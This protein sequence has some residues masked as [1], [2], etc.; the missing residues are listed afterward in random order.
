[1]IE[2]LRI[3]AWNANGLPQHTR[4]LELFLL[5]QK[6]DIVLLSETHFTSKSV[7][8]LPRYSTYMTLRPDG[9]AHGGTAVLIKTSLPHHESTP[10]QTMSLQATSVKIDTLPFPVTISAIYCPPGHCMQPQDFTSYFSTLGTKFIAGGDWNAKHTFWGS[11]LISPRGRSLYNATRA[12]SF[13]FISTGEPTHWPSDPARKPDLIDFFVTH[14]VATNYTHIESNDDLSSDHSPLIL[15]LSTAVITK[16]TNPKLT[17]SKTNWEQYKAYMDENTSLSLRLKDPNDI[18]EAAQYLTALIQKGAVLATPEDKCIMSSNNIPK[19]IKDLIAEKRRQRKKW[20]N[21]R[22][23]NDKRLLNQLTRKIQSL[24][25][26]RHNESFGNYLLSLSINDN[27]LWNA[28]K[29]LKRPQ[30]QVPALKKGPALYARSSAEKA[31]MFGDHLSSVFQPFPPAADTDLEEQTEIEKFLDVPCQMAMPIKPISPS[32]IQYA[33]KIIKKNKAPGYDLITGKMLQELPNMTIILITHI[34]NAMLRLSYWP[35]IWKY[36]DIIM[37]QKPNKPSEEVSS[38]RPISLLPAL[39][40]LFERIF[41]P[42][43]MEENSAKDIVPDHQFGFRS[44]HSTIQQVHRVVNVVASTLEE[45]SHC[46]AAFLD[47]ASA[48]DKVWHTGLLHKLKTLIPQPHYL[49]LKS[50]LSDRFFRVKHDGLYSSYHKI[51]AGVPQ[52]SVLGPFLYVLY[53]NDIPRTDNT[54]L[55]TF[56][57]DTAILSKHQ[58]PVI[59]SDGLQNYLN[60]LQKWLKTWRICVNE[61]KSVHMTFTT[62]TTSCPPVA[63]NNQLLPQDDKVRYLGV[64]LDRKLNWKHHITTK[65]L[66]LKLKYNKM[67]WLLGSKSKLS[68]ENKIILYK[69]VLKPVWTYGIELWGCAKPSNINIIQRFQSK[70]LRQM[71]GA[72]YYVSNKTI[73]EDLQIPFIQEEIKNRPKNYQRRIPGHQNQLIR[74]LQN[75]ITNNKRLKRTYPIDLFSVN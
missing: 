61:G 4:E 69:M 49:L 58:D 34:F 3:L 24:L 19:E 41:L 9:K 59:A 13:N 74:D 25:K 6:I 27:S 21:K 37:V 72:P 33:L 50:Y 39:S 62:R 17:S 66:Q 16:P 55:A 23:P 52:G 42:K 73:H 67:F 45:K 8:R 70:T 11:R 31:N 75:P 65:R 51:S 64:H 14:G 15:T 56:A 54:T 40:K 60:Q 20:Q 1:M 29:G 35:R 30:K 2:S 7:F 26:E 22:N 57:D 18:D 32:D 44:A 36:A 12:G 38:Y 53:T 10:Y 47:V 5:N 71:V 46:S 48:F 68:V 28:T 43:L 63:L